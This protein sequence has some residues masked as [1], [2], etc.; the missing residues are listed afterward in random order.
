[1]Y[2]TELDES[3]SYAREIE[4]LNLDVVERRSVRGFR[5]ESSNVCG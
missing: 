5:S 2:N 4:M 1:M 3:K